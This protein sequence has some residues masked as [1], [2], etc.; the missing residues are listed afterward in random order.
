[1][2]LGVPERGVLSMVVRQ[3]LLL[4]G[5]GVVIGLAA[6]LILSRYAAA[7]LYG[8]D[9]MDGVTFSVVPAVLIAV[10]LPAVLLPALRAARAEPMNALRYE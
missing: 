2:A 5:T 7:L 9:A 10:A 1:M 4:T 6:A 8:V 3:G